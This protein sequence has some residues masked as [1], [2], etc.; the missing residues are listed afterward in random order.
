MNNENII[1]SLESIPEPTIYSKYGSSL[2][3]SFKSRSLKNLI[4]ELKNPKTYVEKEDVHP[5]RIKITDELN[6]DIFVDKTPSPSKSKEKKEDKK[7]I[8]NRPRFYT[9]ITQN[10]D[11]LKYNP[12]YN[13]ISKNIPSV[14]IILTEKE[15]KEFQDMEEKRE[16]RLSP[17]FRKKIKVIDE[18]SKTEK[19]KVNPK[20]QSRNEENSNT[21]ITENNIKYSRN[22]SPKKNDQTLPPI[23]NV[24]EQKERALTLENDYNSKNNHALRFSKYINR[25]F[26]NNS[27]NDKIS[28]LEPYN[29]LNNKN[30]F[31][32]FK[33][34]IYRDDKNFINQASLAVPSFNNYNP[35]YDIIDK[36]NNYA[37]FSPN[38]VK[39]ND[40]RSLLKKLWCSYDVEQEY[41]LIN[42]NKLPSK[43]DINI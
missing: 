7:T 1:R 34:M 38:T 28:Y 14:K 33:K 17:K 36:K 6:S 43:V 27:L 21:F 18:Y 5:K 40:K 31:F 4:Y 3:K 11:Y 10:I 8:D 16:Q 24:P 41:K 9:K 22:D 39:K 35:R 29:Y 12:N 13:S 37:I 15:K 20:I 42:N 25:K 19:R 32:D 23:K 26:V 2:K 30:R